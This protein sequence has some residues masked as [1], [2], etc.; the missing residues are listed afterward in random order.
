MKNISADSVPFGCV[1]AGALA[2]GF[3]LCVDSLFFMALHHE[4]GRT[5]CTSI[6]GAH[7]YGRPVEAFFG[8]AIAGAWIPIWRRRRGCSPAASTQL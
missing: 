3:A 7:G 6:L 2:L 8:L 5:F 1:I 4:Q